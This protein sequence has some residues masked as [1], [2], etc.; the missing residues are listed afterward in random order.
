MYDSS[1]ASTNSTSHIYDCPILFAGVARVFG[2]SSKQREGNVNFNHY[3]V[4]LTKYRQTFSNFYFSVPTNPI[5]FT[6]ER[7]LYSIN[8]SNPNSFLCNKMKKMW[9]LKME[10]KKNLMIQTSQIHQQWRLPISVIQIC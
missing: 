5:D 8:P 4:T 10:P 6:K 9:K 3:G 1:E 7:S 2:K